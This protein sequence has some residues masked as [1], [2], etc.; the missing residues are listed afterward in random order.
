MGSC[1]EP[2]PQL[3]ALWSL[4]EG[5]T[6]TEGHWFQRSDHRAAGEAAT[7]SRLAVLGGFPGGEEPTA[8]GQAGPKQGQGWGGLFPLMGLSCPLAVRL[9]PPTHVEPMP[10]ALCAHAPHGEP[11]GKN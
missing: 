3:P 2:E 7:T 4:L 8:S 9:P 10:L 1:P 11:R 6:Q 5:A